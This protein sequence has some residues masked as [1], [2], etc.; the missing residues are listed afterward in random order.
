MCIVLLVAEVTGLC[1]SAGEVECRRRIDNIDID[2]KPGSGGKTFWWLA[3]R[4]VWVLKCI[5]LE[6]R[7]II[8]YFA[9]VYCWQGLGS[10]FVVV[11]GDCVRYASKA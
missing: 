4:R 2:F 7:L 3:P 11:C 6:L 10:I 8:L 5:L 1:A 9:I